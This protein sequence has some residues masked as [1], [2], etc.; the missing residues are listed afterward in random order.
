M[1]RHI[2]S[3]AD[4]PGGMGYG[5][6][7]GDS[8]G[9]FLGSMEDRRATRERQRLDEKKKTYLEAAAREKIQ[10]QNYLQTRDEQRYDEGQEKEER[11]YNKEIQQAA[12]KLGQKFF[13]DL[14]IRELMK[15]DPKAAIKE[16]ARRGVGFASALGQQY[17]DS[18]ADD[19]I[20]FEVNKAVKQMQSGTPEEIEAGMVKFENYQK[21]ISDPE[22]K[23]KKAKA[24]AD[25]DLTKAKTDYYKQSRGKGGA[26]APKEDKKY[27]IS[28]EDLQKAEEDLLLMEEEMEG[29]KGVWGIGAKEGMTPDNLTGKS[30]AK[31]LRLKRKV[32]EGNRQRGIEWEVDEK[33]SDEI[34]K[35]KTAEDFENKFMKGK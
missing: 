4:V 27:K 26:G 12:V 22:G 20:I 3:L 29:R 8:F 17:P 6:W 2:Y 15:K 11:G 31:Y 32:V 35:M 19:R 14:D 33:V 1:G 21:A 9:R 25:L 34:K 30:R 18:D 10:N 16:V 23:A 5:A 28:D 7:G 13:S 24:A